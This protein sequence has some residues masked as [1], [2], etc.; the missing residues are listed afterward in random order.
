MC[1]RSGT[2]TLDPAKQ[3]ARCC[4]LPGFNVGTWTATRIPR[5]WMGRERDYSREGKARDWAHPHEPI[6]DQGCPAAWVQSGFYRSLSRYYRRR[7]EHGNRIANPALDHCDDAL[8]HEA[9]NV[10]EGFEEH[11]SYEAA[12]VARAAAAAKR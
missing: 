9:I 10:L 7:D 6:E 2:D 8:V 11:A 4:A 5:V 12:K 1:R 3:A